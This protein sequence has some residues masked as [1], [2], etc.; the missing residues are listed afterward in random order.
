[1]FQL[2]LEHGKDHQDNKNQKKKKKKKTA[3]PRNENQENPCKNKGKTQK[4]MV[5]HHTAQ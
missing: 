5:T 4:T 2:K 3:Q 1:M